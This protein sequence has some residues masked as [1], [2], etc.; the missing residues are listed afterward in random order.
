MERLMLLMYPDL[1]RLAFGYL[2]DRMLAE[3][4]VSDTFIKL[5]EKIHTIND[6]KNA[7]GYLKTI[8]VNKSLNLI[9]KRKFETSTEP[10]W[11][12]DSPSKQATDEQEL[13][14]FVLARMDDAQR[15]VILLK[16]FGFTL[17]DIV[18]KTGYTV[19][20]VRLL[21][22]KGKQSFFEKYHKLKGGEL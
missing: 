6:E 2:K 5:I 8:V 12:E 21:V 11:F 22:D 3:D 17:G 10:E 9:K 15:E 18:E 13:V 1:Y 14:R 7:K 20:Q 16:S 4:I 19:N